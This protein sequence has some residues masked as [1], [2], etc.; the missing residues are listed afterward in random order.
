MPL[1]QD[2]ATLSFVIT[3]TLTYHSVPQTVPKRRTDFEFAAW[4]LFEI[5]TPL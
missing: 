3:R 4:K 1:G 5:C 2:I